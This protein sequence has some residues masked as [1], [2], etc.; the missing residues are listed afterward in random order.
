MNKQLWTI[1]GA[2]GVSL[3]VGAAVGY[4]VAQKQLQRA[5]DAILAEEIEATKDFYSRLHKT[6]FATPQ[7][8]AAHFGL[9]EINVVEE[10]DEEQ[11]MAVVN[12]YR[13]KDMT[14]ETESD[15]VVTELLK[16]I[17]EGREEVT[18]DDWEEMQRHRS[19]EEPYILHVDEFMQNDGNYN[20]VELVY[21]EGDGIL[22]DERDEH[23]PEPEKF[24]GDG[25]VL[26]FGFQSEDPNVVYVRNDLLEM[27]F[28]IR[29]ST[30]SYKQEVLGF[31]LNPPKLEKT[32][33]RDQARERVRKNRG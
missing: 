29:R 33:A 3:V 24:I 1:A 19:D 18:E 28:C 26:R 7:E 32:S 11:L 15:P 10:T 27:D 23:M 16:N 14:P 25:K 5:Y 8:A 2:A 9:T 20:Q 13:S 21:F 4:L 17:F 31:D 6:E 30:G 12:N 22:S